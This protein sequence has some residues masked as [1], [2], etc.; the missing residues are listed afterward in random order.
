MHDTPKRARL[1][2]RCKFLLPSVLSYLLWP[3]RSMFGCLASP[4]RSHGILLERC[5]SRPIRGGSLQRKLVSAAATT[6]PRRSRYADIPLRL[7]GAVEV[8]L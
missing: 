6:S 3:A 7:K 5:G 4:S 1:Y 8:D 2:A